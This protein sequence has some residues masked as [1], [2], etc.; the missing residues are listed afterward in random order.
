M[1]FNRIG[2]TIVLFA[3][4]GAISL[5]QSAQPI[6]KVWGR[7]FDPNGA[8]IPRVSVSL[9]NPT[10]QENLRAVTN[11][12]GSFVFDSVKPGTYE[13]TAEAFYFE[14]LVK[15]ISIKNQQE[16][17]FDVKL[18]L[19]QCPDS[20]KRLREEEKRSAKVCEFHEVRLKVDVVPIDYGLIVIPD[21]DPGKLFPNSNMIY[22]GGCVVD[23]YEKA[24]VLFCPICRKLESEWRKEHSFKRR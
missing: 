8:L 12:E 10:T 14:K 19:H 1:L 5:A 24:E 15:K 3:G 7:V 20:V 9:K 22:Y 18:D 17:R 11:E 2:N 6:V 23:C 13:L 16:N 21:D 4:L